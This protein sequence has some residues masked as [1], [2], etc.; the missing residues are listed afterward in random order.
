MELCS[1]QISSS[2]GL[3]LLALLRERREKVDE[4][5]RLFVAAVEK[6]KERQWLKETIQHGREA[7]L[8]SR[9]RRGKLTAREEK[10]LYSR[11]GE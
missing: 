1:L 9:F 6:E 10:L 11:K 5:V 8:Y 3:L 2:A 4:T 7:V